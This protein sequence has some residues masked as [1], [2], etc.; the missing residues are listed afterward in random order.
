MGSGVHILIMFPRQFSLPQRYHPRNEFSK[1]AASA[2]T[3]IECYCG[4]YEGIGGV[5]Q[6]GQ[7]EPEISK[8]YYMIS[9][10]KTTVNTIER[11]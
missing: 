1:C 4:F 8:G 3:V 6:A 9:T 5:E 10:G 7:V 11:C 2:A